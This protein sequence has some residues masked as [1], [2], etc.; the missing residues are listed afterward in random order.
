MQC[1]VRFSV[2][3]SFDDGC[4]DKPEPPVVECRW[5][6][7]PIAID[8][9]GDDP[10]WKI[11]Q[12]IEN[13]GQPWLKESARPPKATTKA[14]LLWDREYLYF[15]ADLEDR[16]LF[17]DIVEHDGRTWYNDVFELFFRPDENK[18]GYF[19]FQV[20]AA[21]TKLD[22]FFAKSGATVGE[23]DGEFRW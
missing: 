3:S 4:Q 13:F 16:D 6:A 18:P 7:D 9:K 11:A 23:R 15:F 12:P 21:G 14:K 2:R 22:I 8:G 19:E 10:D 5:A 1:W 20:N 17:A